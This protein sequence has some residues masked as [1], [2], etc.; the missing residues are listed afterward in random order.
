MSGVAYNRHAP[1]VCVG[2]GCD[3][4]RER[5]SAINLDF[6]YALHETPIKKDNQLNLMN[7]INLMYLMVLD[8]GELCSFQ[9]S[10]ISSV[11][12]EHFCFKFVAFVIG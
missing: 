1:T 12:I 10:H 11:H 6:K 3:I 2:K 4:Y 5:V 9:F 8:K 7:L